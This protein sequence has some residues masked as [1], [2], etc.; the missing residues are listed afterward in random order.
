MNAEAALQKSPLFRLCAVLWLAAMAGV[1]AMAGA[2]VPRLVESA[3][4]PVPL[5][6]RADCQ[7]GPKRHPAWP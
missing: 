1:V 3:S 2:T 7:R 5:P 4:P 6:P